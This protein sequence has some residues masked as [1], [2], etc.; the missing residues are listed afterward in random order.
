MTRR[1]AAGLLAALLA[2]CATACTPLPRPTLSGADQTDLD[3]IAAY[4][5]AMPRFQ[6]RFTQSGDYGPGAGLVWVD[7]PGRLR[8]DYE[9][10]AARVMVISNGRVHVLDRG[11]G[12][13]TTMPVSRTPLGILLD[14]PLHL[15]GA[16]QVDSLQHGSGTL[17]LVL[18][19]TGAAAQGSLTL[20]FADAPLQ[21][22]AVSVTDAYHHVLTMRLSGIET[23]PR[24]TPDL[25][26]VPAS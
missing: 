5:N 15:D 17:R 23:S 19:K 25:F 4:L 21:L 11:N 13:T 2:T 22:L 3:R 7:R 8:I 1:Q 14:A 18:S 16:V 20:D 9:G 6:A 26:Q 24:L 10:A 12:A